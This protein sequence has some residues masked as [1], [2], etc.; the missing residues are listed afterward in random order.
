MNRTERE[1]KLF[2]DLQI[3]CAKACDCIYEFRLDEEMQKDTTESRKNML[4]ALAEVQMLTM[5]VDDD[6]YA[7]EL[8]Q[9]VRDRLMELESAVEEQ[10]DARN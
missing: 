9:V 3:A 7:E 2:K 1:T 8:K 6:A 10:E 5:E 4:R